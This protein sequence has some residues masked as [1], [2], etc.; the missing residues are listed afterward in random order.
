MAQEDEVELDDAPPASNKK[1]VIIM[2]VIMLIAVGAAVGVT[3][4]L[5]GGNSSAPQEVEEPPPSEAIYI[6]MKP[7]T[8][9]LNDN[10]PAKFLQIQISLMTYS[11]D[12]E[13]MI[14][15]HMPVIRNDI[16]NRLGSVTY[17]NASS[18]QGKEAL[19]G[20]LLT[21]TQKIISELEGING[22]DG[23]YF[24]KMIMQ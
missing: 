3:L 9:G 12:A 5:V 14:R 2:V 7:M 17:K 11:S 8:V 18:A 22:V 24:T 13:E 15:M 10:G 6:P 19:R 1:L 21:L 23:I 4:M 16:L 20:E